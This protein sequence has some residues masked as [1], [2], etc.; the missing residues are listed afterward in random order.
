MKID[1]ESGRR[2]YLAAEWLAFEYMKTLFAY[3]IFSQAIN[4][5]FANIDNFAP[6]E[7]RNNHASV[8]NGQVYYGMS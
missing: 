1:V 2:F 4:D 8:K 6:P 3:K 5:F 7:L